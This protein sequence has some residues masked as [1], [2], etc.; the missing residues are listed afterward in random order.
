MDG[1][2]EYVWRKAAAR[3]VA[4]MWDSVR[5]QTDGI[6]PGRTADECPTEPGD[7]GRDFAGE[8]MPVRELSFLDETHARGPRTCSNT[9]SAL[10]AAS[11]E[12]SG[13]A[14]YWLTFRGRRI[15]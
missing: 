3:E 13:S 9:L 4:S 6:R 11:F 7:R 15:R 10:T 2:A 1:G 5:H 8:R 12:C 14:Y